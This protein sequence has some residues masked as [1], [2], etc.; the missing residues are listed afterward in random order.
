MRIVASCTCLNIECGYSMGIVGSN[1]CSENTQ[2][3]SEHA[4]L[5]RAANDPVA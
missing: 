5:G 3:Q 4:G 1:E 2:S